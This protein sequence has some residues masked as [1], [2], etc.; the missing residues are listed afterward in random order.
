MTLVERFPNIA[1]NPWRSLRARLLWDF[2]VS[3]LLPATLHTALA[4]ARDRGEMPGY[5]SSHARA[6][7]DSGNEAQ[8]WRELDGPRWWTA[9]ADHFARK[10]W[11]IGA[12]EQ[13]T[14]AARL[15]GVTERH[16]LLS[17]DLVEFALQLP[18]ERSFDP[19]R[20]RPDLRRAMQGLVPDE[21]R[22]LPGKVDFDAVRGY[23]LQADR[24]VIRELLGT[25]A[26]RIRPFV[27]DDVVAEL[28]SATPERWG[29]L[30]RWGGE[31]MRLITM[32]CWLRAQEDPGFARDLRESGRL[33]P[34]RLE[35]GE[36]EPS[37][38]LSFSHLD[39]PE[40]GT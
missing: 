31:L 10:V 23:S 5:L 14:R 32:E 19:E 6:L 12:P 1:Y 9:K 27:R 29:D 33:A 18:P 28:L 34:P 40:T 13:T 35:I 36:L 4:R 22:L 3:P 17:L 8:R 37:S 7:L 16:P 30:S 39:G 11:T 2:G 21:V 15:G 20:T 25:P 24:T 38:Y 26:A